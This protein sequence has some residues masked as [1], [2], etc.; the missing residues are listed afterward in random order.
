MWAYFLKRM[1]LIVPTLIGITL[2][3][4]LI[5]QMVPGGPVEQALQRMRMAAQ[6]E[7]GP[8]LQRRS[9]NSH[10]QRGT[11]EYQEILRL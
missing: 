4:F 9:G 2:V 8:R 6:S 7:G 3:S 1:F 5:M 10:H 11:G